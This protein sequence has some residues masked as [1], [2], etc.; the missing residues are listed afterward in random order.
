MNETTASTQMVQENPVLTVMVEDHEPVR[1]LWIEHFARSHRPLE[2][3]ENPLEFLGQIDRFRNRGEHVEFYFD[4]NF[5]HV[6]N[7]GTELAKA[8]QGLNQNQTV[9]LITNFPKSCFDRELY[10]GRLQD[11]YEKFPKV[12]FGERFLQDLFDT[13]AEASFDLASCPQS[14][15]GLEKA[16]GTN[17][18]HEDF[19]LEKHFPSLAPQPKQVQANEKTK[20][21]KQ[22]PLPGFLKRLGQWLASLRF[23]PETSPR[24]QNYNGYIDGEAFCRHWQ[25]AQRARRFDY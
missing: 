5:G 4:Q 19:K 12:I 20:P 3:F 9:S 21:T 2:V 23:S 14:P 25:Q 17:G 6:G 10:S 24:Y 18:A 1:R 15:C 16:L 13:N 8:V 11:V 22:T 7:V